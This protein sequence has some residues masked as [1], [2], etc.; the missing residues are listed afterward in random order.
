MTVRPFL[1]FTSSTWS[2]VKLHCQEE[3]E[4]ARTQLEAQGLDHVQTE[5]LRARIAT[6]RRLI[7]L[8]KPKPDIPHGFNSHSA[9]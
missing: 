1:D 9:Y 8:S 4:A 3:I 6:L 5:A 7:D 2:A